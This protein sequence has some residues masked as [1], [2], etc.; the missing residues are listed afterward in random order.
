VQYNDFALLDS[1]NNM[2]PEELA[3]I[4]SI[5]ISVGEKEDDTML[6]GFAGLRDYLKEKNI[7]SVDMHSQ[8]ILGEGHRS[9]IMPAY[10]N[11]FKYLYEMK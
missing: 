8:L 11:A 10:Y 1:L 4:K 3:G 6:E 7:P 2:L 5:Y 9:A